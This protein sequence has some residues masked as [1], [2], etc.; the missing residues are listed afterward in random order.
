MP[1]YTIDQC[2]ASLDDELPEGSSYTCCDTNLCNSAIEAMPFVS[3][4]VVL[5]TITIGPF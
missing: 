4:I 5:L 1:E 2:I 3:L